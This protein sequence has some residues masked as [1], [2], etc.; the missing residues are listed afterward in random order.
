MQQ[1]TRFIYLHC[2]TKKADFVSLRNENEM[3]GD[4]IKS[5]FVFVKKEIFFMSLSWIL[6]LNNTTDFTSVYTS[7]H[8]RNSINVYISVKI[9]SMQNFSIYIPFIPSHENSPLS[10]NTISVNILAFVSYNQTLVSL[11]FVLGSKVELRWLVEKA[12]EWKKDVPNA[13]K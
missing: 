2:T 4:L 7:A 5:Y 1:N 10:I 6:Q 9:F 13:P 12:R 11:N 8:K 3:K